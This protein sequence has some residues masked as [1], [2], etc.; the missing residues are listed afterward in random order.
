MDMEKKKKASDPLSQVNFQC[1]DAIQASLCI[2]KEGMVF[3]ENAA[4]R[5][6]DPKVKEIFTR[7]ALEEKE[8]I[9]SLQVKAR[10]LQPAVSK[11]A[12]GRGQVDAFI[13]EELRG[14]VFPH[15]KEKGSDISE[16]EDDFEALEFG[17]QSEKRSIEVLGKLLQDEKKIDVRAI[18]CHL[19]VEEKKHLAALEELKKAFSRK[20]A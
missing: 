19:L 14:K 6:R 12:T 20:P 15:G 5:A 2:E 7:L 1:I 3:Y 9:Q 13:T 17:I 18:F 4:R 11:R 8:H 16:I 10:F